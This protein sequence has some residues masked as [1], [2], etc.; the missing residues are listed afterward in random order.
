MA[1]FMDEESDWDH[2]DQAHH[3]EFDRYESENASEGSGSG[4]KRSFD[5]ID[6]LDAADR[7]PPQTAQ[8]AI[9]FALMLEYSHVYSTVPHFRRPNAR[10]TRVHAL[11]FVRGFDDEMF[12]RQFRLCRED[13]NHILTVINDNIH[14]NQQK[15]INSSGSAICMEIRLCMTLRL[16]AG[17]S[18][19]DLIWYEVSI[20]HVM[21]Y[22]L[23]ILMTI[24][25][26]FNNICL[27]KSIADIDAVRDGWE[28]L[29]RRKWPDRVL[30]PDLLAAVDGLCIERPRPSERELNGREPRI[31]MNRKGFYAWIA[32]ATCDS[33]ARFT[34]FEVRWPGATSDNIAYAQSDLRRWVD[35]VLA[36]MK[37]GWIAGDDA[38]SGCD[39][40]ILTPFSKTQLRKAKRANDENKLYRKM[41]AFNY[42]LSSMRITIER[43]F[44]M[45]VRRWGILWSSIRWSEYNS[46]IMI[47]VCAKLHNICMDRWMQRHPNP[48]DRPNLVVPNHDNIPHL[49]SP[50]PVPAVLMNLSDEDVRRKMMNQIRVDWKDRLPNRAA[51]QTALRTA[52][53]LK[54]QQEGLTTIGCGSRFKIVNHALVEG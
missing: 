52:Y 8:T 47:V 24:N 43:A 26:C 46:L 35:E 1:S 28:S 37:R 15:A 29:Q 13:F 48:A 27:P 40:R 41:L 34:S 44:G 10:K 17:A 42:V 50:P 11:E 2:F 9:L 18:Y 36:R 39:P 22:I 21:D 23:P 30:M 7:K 45:L 5:A 16:L 49:H 25:A 12:E 54:V 3:I 20:D 38:Y 51:P 53:I 33:N 4:R 6:A 32:C 14:L 19:L 31:F